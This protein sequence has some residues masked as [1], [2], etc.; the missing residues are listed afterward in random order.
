MGQ[1]I[2]QVAEVVAQEPQEPQEV[3]G[4]LVTAGLVC[5]T[6]YQVQPNFMQA[7][8]VA[9]HLLETTVAAVAV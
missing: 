7:V 4:L 6:A 1:A 2:R 8:A 9:A 5:N 3:V